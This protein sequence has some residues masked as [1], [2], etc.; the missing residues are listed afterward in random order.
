MSLIKIFPFF[1]VL[2][3]PFFSFAQE[4]SEGDKYNSELIGGINLNTNANIIGGI[5]ASY[6]RRINA[7][8]FHYF[9]IELVNVKHPKETRVVSNATGNL[10]VAY[11]RNH[12]IPLRLQYGRQF[13]LFHPAEEEGVQVAFNVCGGPTLGIV[14][15]YMVEYDYFNYTLVEPFNPDKKREILGS[16]GIFSG[17]GLAKIVPGLNFKT[18][19]SFKFSQ[20]IGS[21]T[22]IEVGGLI[23][24]YPKN[25][26][27]LDVESTN[28]LK[29]QNNSAFTSVFINVFFGMRN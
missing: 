15:P 7:K 11:K 17:F 9:G 26:I 14:K 12:L 2:V 18:S 27:L 5:M 24:I 20:F 4:E 23:E 29:P 13:I 19:F 21:V 25:I 16:A 22:G 28:P 6:A 1:V 10:F 8:E 3:L